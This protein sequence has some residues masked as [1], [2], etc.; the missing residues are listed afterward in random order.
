MSEQAT[1]V[2]DLIRAAIDT[3]LPEMLHP[4]GPLLFTP[5]DRHLDDL[6]ERIEAAL[7]VSGALLPEDWL[8]L[9]MRELEA[10]RDEVRRLPLTQLRATGGQE[11]GLKVVAAILAQYVHA[12][13]IA[14]VLRTAEAA[15]GEEG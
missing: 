10:L 15:R 5:E 8:P 9:T 4:F 6:A 3:W 13:A 12:P 14:A 1:T 2:R 7:S 11:V